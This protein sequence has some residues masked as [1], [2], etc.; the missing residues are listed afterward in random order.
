MRSARVTPEPERILIVDD[1]ANVLE[2]FQ[3]TLGRAF[4]LVTAVGGRAGIEVARTRGPF[5]V[6]VTD[7]RMPEIDGLKFIEAAR[8]SNPHAVIMMLTG[9][10]DQRTAVDAVNVGH[11][12]RFLTKPCTR[13]VI[14]RAL[15][16]ALAEH[17]LRTAE[18]TLLKQTVGGCVQAL[19][20]VMQLA[21]P[22]LFDR[23]A[24][25]SR[26]ASW[27]ADQTH[28]PH[29]WQ[30]E[31]AAALADIGWVAADEPAGVG[32]RPG[33]DA[34]AALAGSRRH[35]ELGAGVLRVI[36]R[37]DD[38]AAM[39]RLQ[40]EDARSETLART[41]PTVSAGVHLLA[42][43]RALDDRLRQGEPWALAARE[44]AQNEPAG[45]V[46]DALLGPPPDWV[47]QSEGA[48]LLTIASGDVRPGMILQQDVR[49]RRGDLLL[50]S[51]NVI[52]EMIAERIRSMAR[53]S[54]IDETLLV[55]D[56]RRGGRPVTKLVRA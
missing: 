28:H 42:L 15:S 17:R 8:A 7:M 50:A 45:A 48:Q 19:L 4:T 33:A 34:G 46:R 2:S 52:T 54:R 9:N 26:I 36:P 51:G 44:L 1:E 23:A 3:R 38:I 37:F 24:S 49:T 16:D 30:V 43:A 11:A 47:E 40:F 18:R 41:S 31:V 14:E 29:A 6:I 55:L 56:P 25:A 22:E 12:F 32:R 5:A 35:A 20:Q 39:V 27:L 10:S 13:E 21:K 53:T